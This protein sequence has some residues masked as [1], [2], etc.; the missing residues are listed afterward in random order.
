MFLLGSPTGRTN[1][2]IALAPLRQDL[3]CLLHPC[4][5]FAT[6]STHSILHLEGFCHFLFERRPL[7][8]LESSLLLMKFDS[9][10]LSR[11]LPHGRCAFCLAKTVCQDLERLT[12]LTLSSDLSSSSC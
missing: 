5:Y 1:P 2:P 12:W 3:C 4:A 7:P 8:V 11:P 6:G 10:Q 9:L